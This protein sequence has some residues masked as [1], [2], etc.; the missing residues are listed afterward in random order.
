MQL[1]HLDSLQAVLR[2]RNVIAPPLQQIGQRIGQRLLVLNQQNLRHLPFPLSQTGGLTASR[3]FS[4]CF[5]VVP[6]GPVRER[7][8]NRERWT[9]TRA[10]PYLG[11]AAVLAGQESLHRRPR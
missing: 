1:E 4:G 2:D 7:R 11:L 5:A 8:A 3:Y 6:P 10:A 9:L